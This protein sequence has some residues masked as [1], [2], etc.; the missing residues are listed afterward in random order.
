[1]GHDG[2]FGLLYHLVLLM[3]AEVTTSADIGGGLF[4]FRFYK[5]LDA[6]IVFAKHGEHCADAKGDDD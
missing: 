3:Q 2:L 6:I 5:E 4:R 1:M